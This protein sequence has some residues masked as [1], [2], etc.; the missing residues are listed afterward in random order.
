MSMSL[1][2]EQDH[3]DN[4]LPKGQDTEQLIQGL[5]IGYLN[6]LEAEQQQDPFQSQ[7]DQEGRHTHQ[8]EKLYQNGRYQTRSILKMRHRM[9]SMAL[10]KKRMDKKGKE[11]ISKQE[12]NFKSFMDQ[13]IELGIYSL[14]SQKT[15]RTTRGARRSHS[16]PRY[17]YSGL[18]T[19]NSTT[20]ICVKT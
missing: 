16:T 10:N 13:T 3:S 2:R 5:D 4:L 20:Q 18:P 14:V 19:G 6:K 11:E 15:S 12:E 17:V 7:I 8:N 9:G 1:Q